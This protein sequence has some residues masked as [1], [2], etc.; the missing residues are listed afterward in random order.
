MRNPNGGKMK[1]SQEW[2]DTAV[3]LRARSD[4]FERKA[5]A[6]EHALNLLLNNQLIVF[7]TDMAQDGT[8]HEFLLGAASHAPI[9]NPFRRIL[10][11]ANTQDFPVVLWRSRFEP[12]G[13]Y[14]SVYESRE[15]FRLAAEADM[16]PELQRILE[17]A[18]S[19]LK[20][21]MSE[22]NKRGQLFK[23]PSTGAPQ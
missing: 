10:S 3:R 20:R 15:S 14:A 1:S 8:V 6:L 17:S 22:S 9:D 21:Q 23:V 2:R 18:A 12:Y 16:Q 11:G 4:E 13:V 5:E 7:H 19:A